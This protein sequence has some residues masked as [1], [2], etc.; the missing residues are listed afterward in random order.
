MLRCWG[1][2]LSSG[3]RSITVRHSLSYSDTSRD[4]AK[5]WHVKHD[6][7]GH[8]GPPNSSGLGGQVKLRLL[9]RKSTVGNWLREWHNCHETVGGT[10]STTLPTKLNTGRGAL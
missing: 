2:L 3:T 4:N 7:G 6:T 9:S 8:V 1:S 5:A 10:R